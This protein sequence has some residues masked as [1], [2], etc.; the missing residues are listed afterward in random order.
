MNDDESITAYTMLT[1]AINIQAQ[2]LPARTKHSATRVAALLLT[3]AGGP[4]VEK[5]ESRKVT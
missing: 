1:S 2:S 4:N 5:F 3:C